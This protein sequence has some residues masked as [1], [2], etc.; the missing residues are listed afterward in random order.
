MTWREAPDNGSPLI[1]YQYR[2]KGGSEDYGIWTDV[3]TSGPG[4]MNEK[5]YTVTGLTND[6]EY[7]LQVRGV[8][9]PLDALVYG[10]AS[11]PAS[12]TPR[13]IGGTW[14]LE[15]LLDPE[16][17]IAGSD[18]GASVAFRV[19]FS[20]DPANAANVTSLS[21][22]LSGS[23]AITVTL[24]AV[25]PSSVGFSSGP[26]QTLVESV[27]FT[28]P[29]EG[30]CE[31]VTSGG[32]T[33]MTVVCERLL[34]ENIYAKSGSLNS[35]YR[36]VFSGEDTFTYTATVN[37]AESA[38]ATLT[39][40][41]LPA[42]LVTVRSPPGPPINLAAAPG[43]GRV[44]LT[45]EAAADNGSA[46]SKYQ[47]Q[48][49]EGTWQD[50]AGNGAATSVVV[51]ALTN[52]QSYAFGVRA[53][54]S[55][56]EGEAPTATATP[57]MPTRTGTTSGTRQGSGGGGDDDNAPGRP[58]NLTA[59]PR[60]REVT[61][62]WQPADDNGS[63]ITKYQYRLRAAEGG[64]WSPNWT[65]IPGSGADTNSNRVTGLTNGTV[66]VFQV[67]AVNGV[68]F[69]S[70]ASASGKPAGAPGIPRNLTAAP[71]DRKVAL[72][73]DS[74][75]ANGSSITK[76]QYQQEGGVWKDVSGGATA[77]SVVVSGLTNGTG[78]RFNLR[79]VNDVG[80][81]EVGSV[82]AV[83]VASPVVDVR[84]TAEPPEPP[85][86]P[87][88]SVT[89]KPLGT[90]QPTVTREPPKSTVPPTRKTGVPVPL[91]PQVLPSP[92]PTV[93]P[94]MIP[95]RP[96]ATVVLAVPNTKLPTPQ[97][98]PTPT[99]IS[100][101]ATEIPTP[102]A[103]AATP[104]TDRPGPITD[105]PLVRLGIGFIALLVAALI[106][107]LLFLLARRRRQPRRR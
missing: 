97:P 13:A 48:Q 86:T 50:V 64:T 77:T 67:R 66:Y 10:A 26:D 87:A 70:A 71:G 80:E 32:T 56:G 81:G 73:W 28:P 33:P 88:P 31:V 100:V 21:A 18:V 42:L 91:G 9:Q 6:V 7:T 52:G 49:D 61:L 68:G 20:V 102:V 4:E 12:A 54:N 69:G 5:S 14:T 45:W 41:D 43:D 8:N 75:D 58:P 57:T 60:D 62:A 59:L 93:L 104:S 15:T 65:D 24:D 79:A 38:T 22:S 101:A 40:A 39:G 78:Y 25:D 103:P 99:A 29:S 1:G 19:T 44:T 23:P 76:Y 27:S 85:A 95:T 107:L 98:V 106:G 11:E 55:V 90:P 51:S 16:E 105:L 3:P 35:G 92:M 63:P 83:P 47:Y 30:D 34:T 89:P 94:S 74:A 84:P 2:Q 37:G 17:I 46:I 53:V 36:L 82:S 96:R 72:M